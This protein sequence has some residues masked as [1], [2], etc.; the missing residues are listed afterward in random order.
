MK[1]FGFVIGFG[2]GGLELDFGLWGE[3]GVGGGAGLG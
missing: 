3:G 2:L 1:G